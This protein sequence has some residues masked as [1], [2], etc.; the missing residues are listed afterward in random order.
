MDEQ[1]E[2]DAW[3]RSKL[4]VA[5]QSLHLHPPEP[6]DRTL[7]QYEEQLRQRAAR[8]LRPTAHYVGPARDAAKMLANL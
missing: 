6:R 1:A 5:R 2:A 7:E 4:D 8:R 3:V